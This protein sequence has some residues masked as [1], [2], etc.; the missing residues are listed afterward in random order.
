MINSVK[1]LDKTK[2]IKDGYRPIYTNN[3]FTMVYLKSSV[4]SMK[5]LHSFCSCNSLPS[6]RIA[7]LEGGYYVL[8]NSKQWEFIARTLNLLSFETLYNSLI[9]II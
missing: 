7:K 1:R 8:N 3:S 4:N 2:T 5:A 9:K 6:G